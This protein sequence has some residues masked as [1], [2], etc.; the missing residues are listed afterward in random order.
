MSNRSFSLT[1][2]VILM[3]MGVS[4]ATLAQDATPTPTP[5]PLPD[6]PAF[7]GE[8]ESVRRSYYMGEGEAYSATGQLFDAIF[9][10]TCIIRVIDDQYIPA[11][12]AR[13]SVHTR[14]RDFE[15]AIAD[16]TTVIG[17]DDTLAAAYNNRG[18]LYAAIEEGEDAAA[19]F[20]RVMTLEPDNYATANNRAILHMI[21]DEFEEALAVLQGVVTA[22]GI[23]EVLT[24]YRNAPAGTTPD[25]IEFDRAAARAYGLIGIVHSQMSLALY[26]DYVFLGEFRSQYSPDQRI[27]GAA[28][29]LESRFAFEMRLDDGSWMSMQPY[30]ASGN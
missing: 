29:A 21:N 28:G 5:D 18:V 11:F 3:L 2:L 8:D 7:A 30:S 12:M 26:E 9:S 10:Y 22:S 25:P 27:V 17:L 24:A 1:L 6:C 15:S 13:A 14:L 19:D 4:G 20:G 16:Y 23:E